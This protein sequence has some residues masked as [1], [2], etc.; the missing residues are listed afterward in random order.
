MNCNNL[1]KFYTVTI[2]FGALLLFSVQPMIAK[3]ILPELGGS[4]AVWQTVM[5]FFQILLL[6]GYAYV[7]VTTTKMTL[8]KQIITHRI[9]LISALIALPFSLKSGFIFDRTH[10]PVLWLFETLIYSISLPFFVLS[11]TAPILQKWFSLTEHKNANNPYFLYSASNA[12]SL[13]AL[14]SYPFII[15]PYLSLH[16]QNYVWSGLFIVCIHRDRKYESCPAIT[17]C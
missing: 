4:P 5:L 8:K 11:T 7:H 16:E 2:F 12:G 14:L 9:V 1:V 17:R 15:E 13:I 3:M 10:Y 6:A